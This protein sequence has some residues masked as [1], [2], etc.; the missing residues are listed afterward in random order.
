MALDFFVSSRRSAGSENLFVSSRRSAGSK[1]LFPPYKGAPAMSPSFVFRTVARATWGVL[2]VCAT[3]AC[4]SRSA[5][6]ETGTTAPVLFAHSQQ[7]LYAL[8]L[9]SETLTTIGP[10]QGCGEGVFDLAADETGTLLAVA[11]DGVASGY[12]LMRVDPRTA[13][14][15]AIGTS[16]STT[17]RFVN[18]LAFAPRGTVAADREV[19]VGFSDRDY[20]AID[21][22]TGRSSLL[23]AGVLPDG[24]A[25]SGDVVVLRDGR[26]FVTATG[27]GTGTAPGLDC[28]AHDC[29]FE[30]D[31]KTGTL[32][33]NWGDV[34]Y[35]TVYGLGFWGGQLYGFSE[36]GAIFRSALTG[37]TLAPASITFPGAPTFGGAASRSTAPLTP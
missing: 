30:F 4:G 22:A 7:S 25:S 18:G 21:T 14:C 37:R 35:P 27:T 11:Y 5:L 13:A 15:T 20:V 8:D 32:T 16:S 26:A 31:S 17:E 28:E 23:A 36:S 34:G 12:T 3:L 33:K 24:L 19:L 1:N 6:E 29:L 2:A 9:T 10:F